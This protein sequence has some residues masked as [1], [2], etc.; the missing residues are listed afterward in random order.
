[1]PHYFEKSCLT[2]LVLELVTGSFLLEQILSIGELLWEK[3]ETR[4][5]FD[6]FH[7]VEHVEFELPMSFYR[8]REVLAQAV[9]VFGVAT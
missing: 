7:Q 2:K 6:F 1:M 3:R 8:R 9:F 5:V 4:M